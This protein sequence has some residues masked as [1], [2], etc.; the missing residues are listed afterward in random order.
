MGMELLVTPEQIQESLAAVAIFILLCAILL[1]LRH[2][3]LKK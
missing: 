3:P 2:L 1:L